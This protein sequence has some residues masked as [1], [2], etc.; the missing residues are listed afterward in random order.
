MVRY[1]RGRIICLDELL[2][3]WINMYSDGGGSWN[4]SKLTCRTVDDYMH[5]VT[6]WCRGTF[7]STLILYLP[8]DTDTTLN[9]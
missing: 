7:P 4:R 8:Q 9:L 1:C 6:G 5:D 3:V 2:T